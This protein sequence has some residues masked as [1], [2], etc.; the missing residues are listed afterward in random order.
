MRTGPA[1]VRLPNGSEFEGETLYDGIAFTLEGS[2]RHIEGVADTRT[3]R[4][5]P[6]VERTWPANAVAE[7]RWQA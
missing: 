5:G 7:V 4:L 3:V 6:R 1:I 2:L